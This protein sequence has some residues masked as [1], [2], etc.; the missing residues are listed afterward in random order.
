MQGKVTGEIWEII[1]DSSSEDSFVGIFT[2][3]LGE[4]FEG[5]LEDY[6]GCT[7]AENLVIPIP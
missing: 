2:V 6:P 3:I 4:I 1:H 7:L 5:N